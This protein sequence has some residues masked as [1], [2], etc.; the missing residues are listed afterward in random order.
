MVKKNIPLMD[1]TA[2]YKPPRNTKPATY[3]PTYDPY[4]LYGPKYGSPPAPPPPNPNQYL[5]DAE[6]AQRRQLAEAAR[7][8]AEAQNRAEAIAAAEQAKRDTY[9]QWL[10]DQQIAKAAYLAE[11][12]PP[13]TNQVSWGIPAQPPEI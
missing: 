8:Q 7:A 2:N 4:G 6:D 5:I 13:L 10:K 11:N 3:A 1:G 9:A 12:R